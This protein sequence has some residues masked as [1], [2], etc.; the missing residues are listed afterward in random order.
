MRL[1]GI[2]DAYGGCGVVGFVFLV[3]VIVVVVV[4]VGVGVG[5]GVRVGVDVGVVVVVVV[6]DDWA[7]AGTGDHV[8]NSILSEP[9]ASLNTVVSSSSSPKNIVLSVVTWSTSS[10][11][12]FDGMNADANGICCVVC[13]NFSS[14][15]GFAVVRFAANVV[16]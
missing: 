12:T 1:T 9:M 3:G 4:C 15:V 10:I 5:I 16:S 6:D 14:V 2:V 13:A 8:D 11:V 7:G